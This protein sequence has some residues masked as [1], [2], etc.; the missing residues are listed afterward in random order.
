MAAVD[1]DFG[2][3]TSGHEGGFDPVHE[4]TAA[5][6]EAIDKLIATSVD[7]ILNAE[8]EFF[9]G[10][11]GPDK[12]GFLGEDAATFNEPAT[13]GGEQLQERLHG[14]IKAGSFGADGDDLSGLDGDAK[15]ID[16][17]GP[18]G[19]S[20]EVGFKVGRGGLRGGVVGFCFGCFGERINA[21]QTG[22]TDPE[23]PSNAGIV[24]ATG[25]IA[26]TVT[27]NVLPTGLPAASFFRAAVIPG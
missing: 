3:A 19:P 18:V 15:E 14:G 4:G 20:A 16:I 10:G 8:Q 1:G 17:G 6:A 2:G 13:G 24:K 12:A 22:I 26:A 7:G 9:V 5:D 23:E 11:C 25:D 27:T 21:K